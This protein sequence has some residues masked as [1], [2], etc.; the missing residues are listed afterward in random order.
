MLY[1]TCYLQ[2]V[3]SKYILL[4]YECNATVQTRYSVKYNLSFGWWHTEHMKKKKKKLQQYYP[5][6]NAN[7]FIIKIDMKNEENNMNKN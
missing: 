4:W 7:K 1:V 5:I 2:C 6:L 3:V